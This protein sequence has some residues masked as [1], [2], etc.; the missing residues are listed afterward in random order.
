[1]QIQVPIRY[2]AS[3][4]KDGG[5]INSSLMFQ[6]LVSLEIAELSNAE[7]PVVAKWDDSIT[8][9]LDNAEA[10]EPFHGRFA[11]IRKTDD[12]Y[13][14]PLR[15]F[16]LKN[17]PAKPIRMDFGAAKL[18]YKALHDFIV[19]ADP[20]L[21]TYEEFAARAK[22]GRVGSVLPIQ[23]DLTSAAFRKPEEY[24]SEV[25]STYRQDQI[26]PHANATRS[27]AVINGYVYRKCDEPFVALTKIGISSKF[28]KDDVMALRIVTRFSDHDRPG[29]SR[30]Y[31]LQLFHDALIVARRLNAGLGNRNIKHEIY[32]LNE[33]RRPELFGDYYADPDSDHISNATLKLREFLTV[34]ERDWAYPL[35]DTIKLRLYC[36]LKEAL[37][38]MPSDEALDTLEVAGG[39]WLKLYAGAMGSA[40]T[41]LKQAVEA[42]SMRSVGITA[43]RDQTSLLMQP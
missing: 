31:P 10:F 3:G 18:Y 40:S 35:D 38:K 20:N 42:A 25:R 37:L 21:V 22:D 28:E 6:E 5:K 7:A 41:R 36:D 1:M 19:H 17:R 2:A 24:F 16:D 29:Y 13:W 30:F 26:R 15:Q 9:N 39:E 4:R 27:L 8:P 33:S 12:A 34:Q 43:S 11:Y 23:R 14:C 32:Q